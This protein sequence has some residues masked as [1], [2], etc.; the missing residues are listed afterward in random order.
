MVFTADRHEVATGRH[1]HCADTVAGRVLQ[2]LCRALHITVPEEYAARCVAGH[3]FLLGVHPLRQAQKSPFPDHVRHGA[4]LL[5]DVVGEH[6]TVQPSA[7]HQ[8]GQSH[9]HNHLADPLLVLGELQQHLPAPQVPQPHGAVLRARHNV[10]QALVVVDGQRRDGRAVRVRDVPLHRAL[11]LHVV[12]PHA[13]VLPPRGDARGPHPPHAQQSAALP[14]ARAA[15]QAV[16]VQVPHQQRPVARPRGEHVGPRLRRV[17]P[18]RGGGH[19]VVGE[20]PAAQALDVGAGHAG[21]RQVRHRHAVHRPAARADHHL[22]A[23]RAR[24]D[25]RDPPV[26]L[27]LGLQ[28]PLGVGPHQLLHRAVPGPAQQRAAHRGQGGQPARG[29]GDAGPVDPGAGPEHGQVAHGRAAHAELAVLGEG[30]DQVVPDQA[31]P[32]HVHGLQVQVP[33]AAGGVEGQ[34]AHF[35]LALDDE[36]HLVLGPAV[37]GLVVGAA[38]LEDGNG[39]CVALAEY[40]LSSL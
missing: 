35:H 38:P 36:D 6:G 12:A 11:R 25:G 17:G 34:R 7:V 2:R 29:D 23:G 24:G 13:A 4:A 26:Q 21:G 22:L 15:D 8:L 20:G 16:V 9:V 32:G 10:P 14:L 33:L 5:L 39:G 18:S 28:L 30:A 37:P 40:H 19:P 31:R 1:R 27:H 3:Q